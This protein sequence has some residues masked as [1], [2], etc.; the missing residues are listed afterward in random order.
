[1]DKKQDLRSVSPDI[2]ACMPKVL[3]VLVTEL[4]N[5]RARRKRKVEKMCAWIEYCGDEDEPAGCVA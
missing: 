2:D 3:F 5:H 4:K 1:M